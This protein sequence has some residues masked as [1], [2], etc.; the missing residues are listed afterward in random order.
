M[1]VATVN[2][3]MASRVHPLDPL[4]KAELVSVIGVTLT[5]TLNPNPEP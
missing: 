3:D 1:N 5:L 2:A 4:S